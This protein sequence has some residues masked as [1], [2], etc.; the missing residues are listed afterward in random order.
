MYTNVCI[1]M[2]AALQHQQQQQWSGAGAVRTINAACCT[3]V[4]RYVLLAPRARVR[5]ATGWCSD[6]YTTSITA[7]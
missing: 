7:V 5:L 4:P 3:A 6:P 1:Y 2:S